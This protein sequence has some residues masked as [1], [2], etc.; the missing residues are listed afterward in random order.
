ML[1]MNPHNDL[2]RHAE[3]RVQRLESEA[4]AFSLAGEALAILAFGTFCVLLWLSLHLG[5][6]L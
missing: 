3:I 1:T 2:L 5:P 4:K 6:V